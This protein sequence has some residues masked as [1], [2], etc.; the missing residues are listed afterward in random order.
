MSTEPVDWTPFTYDDGTEVHLLGFNGGGP[1]GTW[2]AITLVWVAPDGTDVTQD[3]VLSGRP[4]PID[5]EPI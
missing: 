5:R 3:Y 1:N 4:S 2:S